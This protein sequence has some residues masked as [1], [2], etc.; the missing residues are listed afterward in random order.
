M[1]EEDLSQIEI[2]EEVVDYTG[3]LDYTP[4]HG[5]C[6]ANWTE[7]ADSNPG[8]LIAFMCVL[9]CKYW[10]EIYLYNRQRKILTN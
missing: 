3:E 4:P 1:S 8:W 7:V 2:P 10:F 9:T 5:N 6:P